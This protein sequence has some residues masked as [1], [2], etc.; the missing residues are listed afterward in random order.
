MNKRLTGKRSDMTDKTT[1]A[2]SRTSLLLYLALL[3]LIVC[4]SALAGRMLF[5]WE[6][7]SAFMPFFHAARAALLIAALALI[8][9]IYGLVSKKSAYIAPALFAMLLAVSPLLVSMLVVGI[10]GFKAPMI[11]DIST[12]LSNPPVFTKAPELRNPGDNTL[13]YGGPEIAEMQNLHFQTFVQ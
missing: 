13:E 2:G 8:Q 7:M 6:P 1:S 3:C 10:D 12:D 4:L 5:D 9:V 11:H